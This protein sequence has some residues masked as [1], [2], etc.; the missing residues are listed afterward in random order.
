MSDYNKL[1]Y[2]MYNINSITKGLI[3]FV[4]KLFV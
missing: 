2:T 4:F 3:H 1:I